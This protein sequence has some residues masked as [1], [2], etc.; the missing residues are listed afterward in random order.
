M[1]GNGLYAGVDHDVRRP[2]GLVLTYGIG[3]G[4]VNLESRVGLM[5]G[6]GYRF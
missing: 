4:D 1:E 5:F 2:G 3:F 6:F